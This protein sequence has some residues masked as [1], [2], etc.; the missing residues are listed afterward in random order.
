MESKTICRYCN[1]PM[2]FGQS[3]PCGSEIKMGY[4]WDIRERKRGKK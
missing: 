4:L 3:C 1:D 2:T